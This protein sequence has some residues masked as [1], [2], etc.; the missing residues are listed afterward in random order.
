M[1]LLWELMRGLK[2]DLVDE[3]DGSVPGLDQHSHAVVARRD[4]WRFVRGRVSRVEWG[5]V[6]L[7][8]R[9]KK[10]ARGGKNSGGKIIERCCER[11]WCL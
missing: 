2:I 5:G 6:M 8:R 9:D 1:L 10:G 11:K 7:M 3:V 4:A